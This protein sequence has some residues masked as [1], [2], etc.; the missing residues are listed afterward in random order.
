MAIKWTWQ[1]LPVDENGKAYDSLDQF[2]VH[3]LAQLLDATPFTEIPDFI[4]EKADE[5]REILDITE[6]ARP[7]ARGVPKPRKNKTKAA[8]EP[9]LPIKAA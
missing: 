1:K 6:D 2:K 7:S 9:E 8:P 5:I 4:V 3:L